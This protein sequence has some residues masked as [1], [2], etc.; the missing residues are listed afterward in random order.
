M[1]KY[2][3][4]LSGYN[5]VINQYPKSFKVPDAYLRKGGTLLKLHRTKE[6]I[7][8]F[9]RLIKLYPKTEAAGKA[10]KELKKMAK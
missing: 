7:S 2:K 4:A 1:G 5:T 3:E 10:A 9:K 8:T 6:S